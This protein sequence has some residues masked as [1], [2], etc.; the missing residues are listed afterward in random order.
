METLC[1]TSISGIGME[2][3]NAN[4]SCEVDFLSIFGHQREPSC[5]RKIS[6]NWYFVTEIVPTNCDEKLLY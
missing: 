1:K 6:V 5:K 4:K 2:M 3:A